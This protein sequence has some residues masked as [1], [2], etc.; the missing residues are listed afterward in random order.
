MDEIKRLQQLAGINEIK[1]NKPSRIIDFLNT[2]YEKWEDIKERDKIKL[3][4]GEIET[5]E[6]V[7][8]PKVRT[9]SG[10]YN[11]IRLYNQQNKK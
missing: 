5:V 10:E 3:P 2:P 1:V 7:Y 9:K 4:S 6:K 8:L 11:L